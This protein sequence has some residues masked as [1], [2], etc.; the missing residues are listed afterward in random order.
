MN[1]RKRYGAFLILSL[2]FLLAFSLSAFELPFSGSQGRNAPDHLDP[3]PDIQLINTVPQTRPNG[4]A[5]PQKAIDASVIPGFPIDLNSASVEELMLLPGIGE[6]TAL[7]IIEKRKEKGGFSSVDELTEVRWV[8][9]VKLER[10]R[11]LVTVK[12]PQNSI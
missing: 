12:T 10:I 1:A 8:G 3:T 11:G 9:K 6:K 2:L 7:R 4:Q 5:G